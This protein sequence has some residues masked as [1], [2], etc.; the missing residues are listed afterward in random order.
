MEPKEYRVPKRLG[1]TDEIEEF[2]LSKDDWD[3]KFKIGSQLPK[4]V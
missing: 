1:T 2:P 4:M 3:R